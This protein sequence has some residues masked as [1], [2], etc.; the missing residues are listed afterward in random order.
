MLKIIRAKPNPEGENPTDRTIIDPRYRTAGE[1]FDIK[2]ISILGRSLKGIEV[3]TLIYKKDGPLWESVFV[4]D[5]SDYIGGRKT[6]RIHSG[7]KVNLRGMDSVDRGDLRYID[8]HYFTRKTYVLS[9]TQMDKIAIYDSIAKKWIDEVYYEKM[10]KKG[11]VLERDE[12][13]LIERHMYKF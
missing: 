13:K 8:Q 9:N 4:F 6:I 5:S 1:W 11:A 2:N 12:D 3:Y 7:E 10:P